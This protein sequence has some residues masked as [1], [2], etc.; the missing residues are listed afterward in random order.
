M[1][2]QLNTF[3][4]AAA[5]GLSVSHTARLAKQGRILRASQPGG[6]D[7]LFEP[8]LE[9]LPPNRPPGRPRSKAR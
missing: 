7:W 1:I 3:Q 9:V 2:K 8:P 6:R 5:L 4:V